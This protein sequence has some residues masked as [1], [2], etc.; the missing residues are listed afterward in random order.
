MEENNGR[1][2]PMSDSNFEQICK[3]AFDSTGISLS[4]HKK[5][6]VY[7]R[8]ARRIRRLALAGFDAYCDLLASDDASEMNEFVNAITTNLT[9][10]FRE[11][12]HFDFLQQLVS[13]E[14]AL[15]HKKGESFRI[16]SAGCSS[17]EEPYSIAM[18]LREAGVNNDWNIKILATDLDSNMVKTAK[19]GIYAYERVDRMSEA[20]LRKYFLRDRDAGQGGHVRVKDSVRELITFNRLNL[21][22][23]WPMRNK[24]DI[25]FC[26][27]VVIYFTK[28]TQRVLFGRYADLLKSDAHVF[29]GHSESLNGI[30]DRFES[31]GNTIYRK[32]S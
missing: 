20:L 29:I 25:I 12:H 3:I 16:W 32:I 5:E 6:M 23:V 13:K 21:M 27:N 28:E 18:S 14:W 31:I 1:E 8:L 24:F 30:S 15:R 11:K 22:E 17:G 7:S 9:S 19:E 26:R 2:F 4:R 10:F